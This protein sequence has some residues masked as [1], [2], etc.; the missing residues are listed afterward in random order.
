MKECAKCGISGETVRLFDA[1]SKKGV[2]S[3][4]PSC[5]EVDG[6]PIIQ[7]PTTH[8]L[9][10]VESRANVYERLSRMAGV[11]PVEH[12]QKFHP[13]EAKKRE[14]LAAQEVSL[15]QL[16]DRNYEKKHEGKLEKKPRTDLV[17]NFHWVVMRVRRARKL[18]QDELARGIGESVAAIK[19]VEQGV[20]PEDDY[21][22]VRKLEAF[23]GIRIVKAENREKSVAPAKL[24]DK[25]GSKEITI[26]DLQEVKAVQ[27]TDEMVEEFAEEKKIN[28]RFS[29]RLKRLFSKNKKRDE[30]LEEDLVLDEDVDLGEEKK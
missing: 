9:K 25:V 6:V 10:D 30:E 22:L 13:Q 7:K 28:E 21:R 29:D 2:V 5:V 4:C 12:L 23:L 14:K 26:G 27:D 11:D 17:E 20:L 18:T 24:F 1:I 3:L 8:Q 15:R 16:V 19:M